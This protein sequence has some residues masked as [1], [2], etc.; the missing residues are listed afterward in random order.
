MSLLVLYYL[1]VLIYLS[2][3][4]LIQ[5]MKTKE[6]ML[7]WLELG[8]DIPTKEKEVLRNIFMEIEEKIRIYNPYLK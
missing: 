4:I 1:V 2:L 3:V 5:M 8:E 6:G 7:G